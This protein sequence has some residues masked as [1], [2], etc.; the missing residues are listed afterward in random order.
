MKTSGTTKT[1]KVPPIEN[2]PSLAVPAAQK[3]LSLVKGAS[4]DTWMD[5]WAEDAIV[6]FP[7]APDTNPR[8]L[9]GKHAIYEYYKKVSPA[10]ELREERPLVAYPSSDP[11]VGVFEISLKFFIRSTKKVYDQ[12]YIGVVKVRDDGRIVFYREY[13]D[14]VRAREAFRPDGVTSS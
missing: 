7:Y 3:Y 6:E 9:E 11:R 8:R 2:I 5:I 4:L 14:P 13:F 10:F 1:K 12:D